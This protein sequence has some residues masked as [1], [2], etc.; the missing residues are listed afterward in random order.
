MKKKNHNIAIVISEFN[1]KVTDAL[2]DGAERAFNDYSSGNLK[3]VRVPGAFEIPATAKKVASKLSVDAVVTLGAVIKG[4]TR[5]FDF[6][7]SECT[8]AIQQLTLEFDIPIIFG[9]LTTENARQ[10]LDRAT[11]KDKGYE[12]MQSAFDMINTF[13]EI[14]QSS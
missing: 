7:S 14:E 12:V 13:K 8:R 5:H 3:V 10:A 11:K 6:I 9:V 2:L 1:R 4:E